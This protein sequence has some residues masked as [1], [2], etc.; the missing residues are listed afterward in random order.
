MKVRIKRLKKNIIN[1]KNKFMRKIKR[2]KKEVYYFIKEKDKLKKLKFWG[3][4][5]Y[6][7][8][9]NKKSIGIILCALPFIIMDIATRNFANDIEFSTMDSITPKLFSI[10]YII[11]ILGFIFNLSKKSSYYTYIGSFSLFFILFLV[12]NVYYDATNNFLVFLF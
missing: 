7:F 5:L 4:K 10:G 3:K 8:L 2:I 12:H 1:Y 9:I 11:L 6:H